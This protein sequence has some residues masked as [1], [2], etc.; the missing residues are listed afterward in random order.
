MKLRTVNMKQ[1]NER[2]Y[3]IVDEK[4]LPIPRL[5]E[6]TLTHLYGA[7]KTQENNA[8]HLIHIERWAA[9]LKVDLAE[10]VAGTGFADTGL[11]QSFLKHLGK[12]RTSIPRT[13]NENFSH[14][15]SMGYH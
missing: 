15:I 5:C 6:F 11:Y 3:L 12:V 9:M 1:Y 4:G 2:K 14:L 7:E 8:N 10:I 13:K